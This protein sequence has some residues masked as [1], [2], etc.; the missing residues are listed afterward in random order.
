MGFRE[1]IQQDTVSS[2]PIRDAAAIR[3][4]TTLREAVRVMQATSL[5]CAVIVDES[6]APIGIFTE[7]SL[8]DALTRDASLD[9]LTVGGLTDPGFLVIK[10]SDPILRVWNA[11][12]RDGLRFVCVTD[13][14]GKFIGVTGQRGLAEYLA[15]SFPQEVLVQRLG[16]TPW[17][18]QREGA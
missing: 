18:Q 1:D 11:V 5:G 15:E 16:S 13:D 2:L 8:L 10:Q 12:A 3:R 6:N 7:Q 4:D 14:D 17:M 9:E